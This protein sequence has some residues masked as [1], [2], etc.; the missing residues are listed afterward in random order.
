VDREVATDEMLPLAAAHIYE[1]T[2]FRV[3]L[4]YKDWRLLPE[5]ETATVVSDTGLAAEFVHTQ[6]QGGSARAV[7]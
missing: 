2:G 3:S 1:Q 5:F 6:I 4:S 7:Q